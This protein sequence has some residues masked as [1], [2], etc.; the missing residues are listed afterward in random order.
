M[1]L[2]QPIDLNLERLNERDIERLPD[3][4]LDRLF[5]LS[6]DLILSD[7]ELPDDACNECATC[8]KTFEYMTFFFISIQLNSPYQNC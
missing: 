2:C 1:Y 6:R 5:D 7:L 3:L 4:E 8:F